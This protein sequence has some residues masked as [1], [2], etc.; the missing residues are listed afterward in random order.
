MRQEK[1]KE[2]LER[3][4][5]MV[6][7]EAREEL[8]SSGKNNTKKGSN[9]IGK[10]LNVSPNS[11]SLSF[12]MEDYLQFH[13]QGVKGKTSTYPS[14]I[15]SPFRFG[16]GSGPVGGLTEGLEKWIRQRGI[17]GRERNVKG[18]KG[19]FITN[20]TLA[21]LM[22]RSIYNKG[23]KGSMFFTRPF[24]KNFKKLPDEL[25]EAFGL[26]VENFIKFTNGNNIR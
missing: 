25:V 17:K 23:L 13:D 21:L 1:V 6:I 7:E 2:A 3:F 24:E 4:S 19:R 11:F 18:E 12:H 16:S 15:K 10:D 8:A 9:S 5:R 20:K 26:D 22:A 14:A